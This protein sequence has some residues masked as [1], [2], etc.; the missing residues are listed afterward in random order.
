MD[1][2]RPAKHF[3]QAEVLSLALFSPNAQ[4]LPKKTI[5]L[6]TCSAWADVGAGKARN[7]AGTLKINTAIEQASII[8]KVDVAQPTDDKLACWAVDI[9]TVH[10]CHKSHSQTDHFSQTAPATKT[11]ATTADP[12]EFRPGVQFVQGRTTASK[13]S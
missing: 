13:N 6:R 8:K 11:P 3:F 5:F 2:T 12:S 4:W 7:K 1:G 9:D 10:I